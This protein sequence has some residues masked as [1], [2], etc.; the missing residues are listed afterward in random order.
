[1]QKYVSGVTFSGRKAD[2]IVQSVKVH[3]L[4]Y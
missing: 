3:L 1:M 2:Y 4:K